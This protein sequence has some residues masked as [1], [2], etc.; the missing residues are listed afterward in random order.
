MNSFSWTDFYFYFPWFIF[1]LVDKPKSLKLCLSRHKYKI[2]HE[3]ILEQVFFESLL[4]YVLGTV[5]GPTVEDE[6]NIKSWLTSCPCLCHYHPSSSD[7]LRTTQTSRDSK[8]KAF[9]FLLPL[10]NHP[11]PGSIRNKKNIKVTSK[12]WKAH[13]RVVWQIK[14]GCKFSD[15]SPT[16]RWGLFSLPLN[17]SW[18]VTAL[19]NGVQFRV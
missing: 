3:G 18:P 2:W 15:T 10:R 7:V 4:S 16:D 19:T 5:L 17:L 6:E 9:L 14:D 12:Q 8:E 1:N 11:K 13:G